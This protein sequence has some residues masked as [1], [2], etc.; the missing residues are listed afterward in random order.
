MRKKASIVKIA[1]TNERGQMLYAII[2]PLGRTEYQI[3]GHP[4]N[5]Q[6]QY[7]II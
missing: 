3:W 6:N 2:D 5:M 4:V 7:V 1:G